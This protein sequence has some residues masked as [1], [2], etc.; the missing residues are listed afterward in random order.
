M[1][2]VQEEVIAGL[3]AQ[4]QPVLPEDT[5]AEAGRKVLLDQFVKMLH[6]E[7]G[8]RSGEDI[9]DVHDMRVATR[10]MRSALRLLEDYYK[11]KLVRVYRRQLRKIARALGAV[12]DLDVLIADVKQF[13][14]T[15]GDT[16]KAD[17]QV[18]IDRLD[19][20]RTHLRNDLVRV[21]DKGDYRRFVEDFSDFLTKSGAGAKNPNGDVQPS[22]VRHVLPALLYSHVGA[23]RAYDAVLENA[24]DTT[25]HALR[26]E[27]K[28]LRYAVSLFAD[29]LGNL[30]D[31]VKEVKAMQD[32]LGRMQDIV[33]AQAVLNPMVSELSAGQGESLQLYLDKIEAERQ[34][35]RQRVGD[36]WKKFN[37]KTVQKQLATAV[38]GL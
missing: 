24:D 9:E 5:M 28:R 17:I 13:Q 38:S 6:H 19:E 3:Q 22:Q 8:S 10:R 14:T 2:P 7:N 34:Q 21:L 25:L 11:P 16:Q 37:A 31:F 33:T 12:R 36:M 1:P 20:E 15:L 35:L 30:K 32:H 23:V 26:I 27:F 18:V 29:V 4:V